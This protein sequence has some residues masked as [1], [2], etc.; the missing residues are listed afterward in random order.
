MANANTDDREQSIAQLFRELSQETAGL[1]REELGV[2]RDE[3]K[4]Q[5]RRLG[6]SAGLLGGAGM[7]GLGAFG[8]FTAGLVTAL[9][10][11]RSGRGA[12]LVSI[13]YGAGAAGLGLV[14]RDR[15]RAVAP[16]AAEAVQ[17]DVQ[18]AARG[19]RAGTEPATT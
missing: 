14:A 15:L 16:E 19:V 4:Q 11:G 2:V 10:R 6:A 7:L 1:V 8:A 13:L 12:L 5:G 18:A 17:R 3:L 9:G